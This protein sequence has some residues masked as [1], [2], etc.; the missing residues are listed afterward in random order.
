MDLY[1]KPMYTMDLISPRDDAS[2]MPL[3]ERMIETGSVFPMEGDEPS[4]ESALLRDVNTYC[5]AFAD[6]VECARNPRCMWHTY[7]DSCRPWSYAIGPDF[8]DK[9]RH[10][11]PVRV[12][13]ALDLAKS[14]SN[15]RTLIGDNPSPESIFVAMQWQ[16]MVEMKHITEDIPPGESPEHLQAREQAAAKLEFYNLQ[17]MHLRERLSAVGDARAWV[18][19]NAWTFRNRT[20][21]SGWNGDVSVPNSL[22]YESRER[23]IYPGDIVWGGGKFGVLGPAH[24]EVYIGK[25]PPLTRNP[26]KDDAVPWGVGLGVVRGS[27]PGFLHLQTN[28][29]WTDDWGS[30]HA[31]NII[32]NFKRYGDDI[33]MDVLDVA[34]DEDRMPR[35]TSVKLSVSCIGLWDYKLNAGTPWKAMT[36]PQKAAANCQQFAMYIQTGDWFS[37]GLEIARERVFKLMTQH[38]RDA[39]RVAYEFNIQSVLTACIPQTR[40][41]ELDSQRFEAMT[42]DRVRSMSKKRGVWPVGNPNVTDEQCRVMKANAMCFGKMVSIRMSMLAR[43][44]MLETLIQIAIDRILKTTLEGDALKEALHEARQHPEDPD[45]IRSIMAKNHG[46]EI[47]LNSLRASMKVMTGERDDLIGQVRSWGVLDDATRVRAIDRLGRI[48][49][50]TLEIE[51]MSDDDVLKRMLMTERDKIVMVSCGVGAYCR[52][53]HELRSIL[54][55]QNVKY[56]YDPASLQDM[57]PRAVYEIMTAPPE[58]RSRIAALGRAAVASATV[59]ARKFWPY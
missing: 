49:A 45:K 31:G 13:G 11:D 53:V 10:V 1:P 9:L 18:E 21:M 48:I 30:V 19:Q 38:L 32:D 23:T 55:R 15:F 47:R 56:A 33:T 29:L 5:G 22:M 16:Q 54:T 51:A 44:G 17:V 6:Q 8:A 40:K 12:R 46:C 2:T 52:D 27:H 28:I 43:I 41:S 20:I 37:P 25:F 57:S 42:R 26:A 7:T 50:G 3:G 34:R 36:N 59:E 24:F 39:I 14:M 58:L 35:L 4:M